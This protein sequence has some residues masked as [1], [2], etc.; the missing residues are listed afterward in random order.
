MTL[1]AKIEE[2]LNAGKTV[3]FTTYLR[4]I[5]VTPKNFR[6]WASQGGLFKT[7]ANGALM[8]RNGKGWVC[9]SGTKIE[10]WG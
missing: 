1:Q 8:M 9:V 3:T 6:A 10:V 4:S 5:K 7:D 2:V